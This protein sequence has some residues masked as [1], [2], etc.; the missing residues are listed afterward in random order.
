VLW[1]LVI[2]GR[3]A[4]SLFGSGAWP[5]IIRRHSDAPTHRAFPACKV[6]FPKSPD[7]EK[8]CR[9]VSPPAPALLAAAA[10]RH[11]LGQQHCPNTTCQI[12]ATETSFRLSLNSLVIFFIA[13]AGSTPPRC[14]RRIQEFHD[15]T[16]VG[17]RENAGTSIAMPPPPAAIGSGR[18]IPCMQRA[19]RQRISVGARAGSSAPAVVAA[20][21]FLWRRDVGERLI[22]V[23]S[24][25]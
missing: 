5:F 16:V 10:G 15:L 2:G 25:S 24:S 9:E 17:P 12:L 19:V 6:R 7:S 1:S 18:S 14:E 22:L 4:R 3:F 23:A 8:A 20:T 21:A 13:S 11:P